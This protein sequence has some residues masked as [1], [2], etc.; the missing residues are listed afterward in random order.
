VSL[1][2]KGTAKEAII[3]LEAVKPCPIGHPV[4]IKSRRMGG[5]TAAPIAVFKTPKYGGFPFETF[6]ENICVP[7]YWI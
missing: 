3:A 1:Q 6:V 2:W 5:A 4:T 7:I